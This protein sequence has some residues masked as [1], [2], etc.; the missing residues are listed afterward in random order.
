MH[1]SN[2]ACLRLSLYVKSKLILD[3]KNSRTYF[4][5]F[6]FLFSKFAA[7]NELQILTALYCSKAL[8][9]SATDRK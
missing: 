7:G 1:S 2:T 9:F 3:V 6:V 8:R 5:K 4:T